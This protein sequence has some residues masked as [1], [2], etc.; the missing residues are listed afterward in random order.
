LSDGDFAGSPAVTEPVECALKYDFEQLLEGHT[1]RVSFENEPLSVNLV[2]GQC[3]PQE[4]V[5]QFIRVAKLVSCLEALSNFSKREML[6]LPL[7][8]LTQSIDVRGP[9]E[10]VPTGGTGRN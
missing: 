4:L 2:T 9:I 5:S 8:D 6:A 1:E 3:Q 7:F 10:P